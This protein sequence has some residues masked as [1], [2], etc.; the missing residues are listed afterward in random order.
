MS[1]ASMAP[2]GACDCDECGVGLPLSFLSSLRER[3]RQKLQHGPMK[4]TQ[5]REL[6]QRVS[7]GG[8]PNGVSVW[9]WILPL[10]AEPLIEFGSSARIVWVQ[11]LPSQSQIRSIG[12]GIIGSSD[13]EQTRKDLDW[14]EGGVY[15]VP[16]NGGKAT[17]LIH[18]DCDSRP[19]SSEHA[20][21]K[22]SPSTEDNG[23]PGGHVI[24]WIAKIPQAVAKDVRFA[25]DAGKDEKIPTWTKT[26]LSLSL[27]T[28]DTSEGGEDKGSDLS[29]S[30]SKDKD[31][32]SSS[33]TKLPTTSKPI[34]WIYDPDDTAV[35]KSA[36]IDA[37]ADLTASQT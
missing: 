5:S 3:K 36:F 22:T 15:L 23:E 2:G 10:G 8:N 17:G 16:S 25:D 34:I 31:I 14:K 21:E 26:F 18:A 30:I 4:R 6:I 37:Q 32:L 1:F 24:I 19:T 11:R 33:A 28:G 27:K 9:K 20:P 13:E 7:Y 29:P 12:Q 35:L